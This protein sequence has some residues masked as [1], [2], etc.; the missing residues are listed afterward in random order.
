ME[1]TKKM[2]RSGKAPGSNL[3]LR[4]KL[5]SWDN[6]QLVASQNETFISVWNKIK[7]LNMW[8]GYRMTI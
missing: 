3:C 7:F 4:L 6:L 5:G 1:K 2:V 8:P